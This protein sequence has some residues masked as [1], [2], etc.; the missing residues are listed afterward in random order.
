MREEGLYPYFAL[1]QSPVEQ[2]ERDVFDIC[3]ATVHEQLPDFEAVGKD[4]RRFTYRLL[5]ETLEQNPTNLKAIL[6]E[7]FKLSV[8]QQDNLAGLLKKT[9]SGRSST[10]RKPLPTALRS[11]TASNRFSTT[12]RF[13]ISSRN[14]NNCTAFL[15]K[16]SGCSA[17]SS[18]LGPMTYH[19]A[20]SCRN[21]ANILGV[22]DI[23]KQLTKPES[24]ELGRCTR[25][26]LMETIPAWPE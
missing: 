16:N 4:A 17:M 13:A 22:P 10:Q 9:I 19:F 12:K 21:I 14:E 26:T 18:S 25:P 6:T 20:R 1:P 2:A 24:E 8:E 5:R 15:S 23:I 3:A 7:V 11:S